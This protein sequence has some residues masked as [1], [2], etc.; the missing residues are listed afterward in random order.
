M[1]GKKNGIE[2]LKNKIKGYKVPTAGQIINVYHPE[3]SLC[4]HL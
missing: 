3:Q 2:L 4:N 1:K